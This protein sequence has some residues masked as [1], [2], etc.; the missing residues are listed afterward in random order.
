[1]LGRGDR[2]QGRDASEEEVQADVTSSGETMKD[3]E[4]QPAW[5]PILPKASEQF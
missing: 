2:A 4:Q 1:M 5:E 3:T